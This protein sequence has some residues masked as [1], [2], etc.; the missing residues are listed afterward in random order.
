MGQLGRITF[1]LAGDG[2]D[3]QLINFVGGAGRENHGVPELRKE[4]EPERVVLIHV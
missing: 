1:R 2:L 4:G 3:A